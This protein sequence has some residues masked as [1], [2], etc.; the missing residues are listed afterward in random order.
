MYVPNG[1][2]A[3]WQMRQQHGI[4]SVDVRLQRCR[5]SQLCIL[6][7]PVADHWPVS[8]QTRPGPCK[9][10]CRWGRA[11]SG[12]R[13]GRRA[14]GVCCDAAARAGRRVGAPL[15]RPAQPVVVLA[16]VPAP[17]VVPWSKPAQFGVSACDLHTLGHT[18]HIV[19]R[20]NTQDAASSR[21]TP[22][23]I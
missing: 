16:H 21:L 2:S 5:Q 18:V 6:P 4:V 20:L 3:P 15:V 14:T 9:P 1:A 8:I 7:L 12:R 17:D 13:R 19:L 10:G 23:N 11:L 22:R